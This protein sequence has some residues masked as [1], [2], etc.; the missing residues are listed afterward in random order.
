MF[1]IW[2]LRFEFSARRDEG[3]VP[4]AAHNRGATLQ[5]L[6]YKTPR[7]ARMILGCDYVAHHLRSALAT[8]RSS[9]LVSLQNHLWQIVNIILLQPLSVLAR[10]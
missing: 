2:S 10:E 3:S 6:K 9:L 1:T 8:L 5:W 7:R 4:S